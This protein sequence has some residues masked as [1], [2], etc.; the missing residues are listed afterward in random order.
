MNLACAAKIAWAPVEDFHCRRFQVRHETSSSESASSNW[1]H[2]R[3][4]AGK[5]LFCRRRC[6][7]PV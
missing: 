3:Q 6:S 7:G 4:A 5:R 2:G 1:D